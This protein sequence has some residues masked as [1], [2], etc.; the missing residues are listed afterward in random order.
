MASEKI[1]IVDDDEDVLLIVQTILDNSG[2]S[3]LL[4]RNGR[5]GVEKA[6][7]SAPDLILLD[8]MMPELSGWEVCTTLKSAPE[9]RQIPIAMLTVKSEIRDLITGMQVGADDYITKPFTRKKLLS[10]VRRLLEEK[11]ESPPAYLTA[12]NEEMRFKNL[13]FDA[14]TE[15]PTVPVIIDALR[16]RLLDNR[17]MGVLYIDVEQYSHIEETYGWEVFD[18]LLQHTARTMRRMI[19]TV[20]AT[21]DFIAVNRTGG[22]DFYV[23]ATLEGG[24]EA[25]TRLQ[26]KARQVEESLR[27]SLDEAF[28]SRIHK[29]IGVFVGHALLRPSPQMRVERLVYRALGQAI[30]VA[31]TKEEERQASLRET[32]KETLRKRRIRTVYQPI[33]HLEA[34]EAF[35]HEALTRGPVETAFESP[36][37]LFQFARENEATWELEQICL[38]S[39]A[40]RLR[41]RRPDSPVHQRR[42]GDD[43]RR[44]PRSGAEAVPPLFSLKCPVVLEVT[45]RS[46]I[47]DVPVFRAA[48][49]QLREQGFR[50]AIDDAGSGYASLQAIAELRPNF[51]KVANTLITGTAQR[52][53]QAGRRRDAGQPLPPH[54]RGLRGRGHRDARGPRGV[55]APRDSV[56]PGLLPRGPGR[57]RRHRARARVHGAHPHGPVGSPPVP[58]RFRLAVLAWLWGALVLRAQPVPHVDSDP[59]RRR[60]HRVRRPALFHLARPG[61]RP[62]GPDRRDRARGPEDLGGD[63]HR[64]FRV[65]GLLRWRARRGRDVGG[66]GPRLS[67]R[68]GPQHAASHR[69]GSGRRRCRRLGQA[70]R[71][72]GLRAL[73]RADREVWVTEPDAEKIEVFRLEDNP[74]RPIRDGEIA[75]KG[76]PE[77]LVVDEER[78]VAYTHLWK[79][80]TVAIPLK[81]RT[82]RPAWKNG[83]E[84]SRGIALDAARGLL[85]VGCSEGKAVTLDA[86]TG[87]IVS[88]VKVG[89]GVDIVDYSPSRGHLYAPGGKSATMAIVDVAPEGALGIVDTVPTAEKGHCVA[90]DPFGNVYVCDPKGGRILVIPDHYE[91]APRSP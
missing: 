30:A 55:P 51:I 86:K 23:F 16:D 15:L 41:A 3:V 24:E 77:S 17:D 20:F 50:I 26:R 90:T 78:G 33:F 46:A 54:R 74:P 71:R 67:L 40:S 60:G 48:L 31:T 39:S 4:A 81:N 19:G 9:T 6:I 91:L 10:T 36:E 11:R 85:F 65:V 53:D 38:C 76:G 75:V 14:V 82:P 2:Y 12:E 56:R 29:R 66:R 61:H 84:G 5:E 52:L 27:G 87:R 83:C 44:S 42:G 22:S 37:L 79:G 62:G 35:G 80:E 13:L 89:A 69:R 58:L 1:L 57:A 18:S 88:T 63:P 73:R 34:M 68:D 47:R 59:G 7:E 45:E 43:H 70:L 72:P 32:F 28:G 49:A 21:E 64:G 25:M 8:V